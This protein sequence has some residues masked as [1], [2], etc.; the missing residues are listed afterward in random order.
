MPKSYLD[1][2]CDINAWSDLP[3]H[4]KLLLELRA[5]ADP[6]FFWNSP[7][8]GNYPLFPSKVE[9]FNNFYKYENNRRIK[10][11]FVWVAGMR[12][13]KTKGAA[14]FSLTEIFKLNM[15]K[16]P[17]E[18]YKLAPNTEISVLNV[19]N[20]RDQAKDTVFRAIEE[21]VSNSPYFMAQNPDLT[22]FQMKFP[23]NISAK[24]LGSN[25]GSNVGRTTKCFVADEIADY[26]YP[27]DTF[28][29]LSKS[30]G[31]FAKWNENIRVMI[32]S[33]GLE[34]DYIVRYY[35]RAKKGLE[36]K[37]NT[38]KNTMIDWRPTWELNPE[39]DKSVL[40]AER[41]KDPIRFDRDY[42]AMPVK[43]IESLFNPMLLKQ[44]GDRCQQYQNLFIGQPLEGSR[45]GFLPD[46]DYTRLVASP[47]ATDYFVTADPA[48]KN[49]A[50]GLAVGYL[51]IDNEAKCI[52]S[53]II[54]SAKG[55][56]IQTEDI[57][58]LLKPIFE[59]LRPK[60]YIYDVYLHSELLSVAQRHGVAPI[61]H[62]LNLNDWIFVR[63]DL[64][65]GVLNIPYNEYLWKEFRELTIIKDKKVDHPRSG[66]KDQADAVA[67]FDSF[68]RRQ[69]EEQRLNTNPAITHYIGQF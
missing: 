41:L 45:E 68:I 44:A 65:N 48:V 56:E 29:K 19:A 37:D 47:D 32:S 62:N 22:A 51:S 60:N 25:L 61:Q 64:Y 2:T 66:S 55:E 21:I 18:Y 35:N 6:V 36:E 14:M 3:D 16:N 63:N 31:N 28:Q 24:A 13:G 50:F 17:Q 12:G 54:K 40:E 58:N 67:Q 23:K 33:P 27:E 5:V 57:K 11:E 49:D 1:A 42:G 8:M 52:G 43:A 34:G 9:I 26:D 20:S 69:Q 30:T 59:E 4:E 46:I 10:S 53:T 7:L 39:M 15:M 38:W